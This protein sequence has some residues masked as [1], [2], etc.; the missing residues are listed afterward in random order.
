MV[1]HKWLGFF[2]FDFGGLAVILCFL[3]QL[4]EK[5][6]FIT[7]NAKKFRSALVILLVF[8]LLAVNSFAEMS[9]IIFGS[10]TA[11]MIL[12]IFTSLVF[13]IFLFQ[14][15]RAWRYGSTEIQKENNIRR[16][17]WVTRVIGISLIIISM[18]PFLVARAMGIRGHAVLPS[19][20]PVVIWGIIGASSGVVL[21]AWMLVDLINR[22]SIRYKWVWFGLAL[23]PWIG[24]FA[25]FA[26]VYFP[27][28]GKQR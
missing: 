8:V 3:F 19:N 11:Q 7:F 2:I 5:E 16:P 26:C 10:P 9:L 24:T 17:R 28:K 23:L 15:I 20:H 4:H 12:D 27:A 14:L 13:L 22:K 25:Y 6:S 21:W 18:I 1:M